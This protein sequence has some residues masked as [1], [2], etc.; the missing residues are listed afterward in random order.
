MSQEDRQKWMED[1]AKAAAEQLKKVAEVLDKKQMARLEEIRVQ[2]L[3]TAA[4]MDEDVAKKLEITDAQKENLQAAQREAMQEMRD[5]GQPGP[6]TFA[7]MREKME[8]KVKEVLTEKQQATLK[9]MAGK[10]FDTAALRGG[11][12]GRGGRGN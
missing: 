12:G 9:E 3:G 4:L 11:P 7:K 2:A 8:A 1:R 10:P 6:E 5:A